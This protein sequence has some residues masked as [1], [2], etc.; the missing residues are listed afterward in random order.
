MKISFRLKIYCSEWGTWE[1]TKNTM[2]TPARKSGVQQKHKFLLVSHDTSASSIMALS[3]LTFVW[4]QAD[5][6]SRVLR[7]Q[8]NFKTLCRNEQ[9]YCRMKKFSAFSI[10]SKSMRLS[11]VIILWNR[12]CSLY[13]E[14]WYTHQCDPF[15]NIIRSIVFC[16]GV[17]PPILTMCYRL[18]GGKRGKYWR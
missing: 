2:L 11:W 18:W 9:K 1:I 3:S 8:K 16:L 13:V 6:I 4:Y 14:F 12:V 5:N 15:E 17:P 7:K 10:C